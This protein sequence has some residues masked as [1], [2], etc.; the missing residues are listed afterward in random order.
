[1][2]EDEDL[3]LSGSQDDPEIDPET[4]H[5]HTVDVIFALDLLDVPGEGARLKAVQFP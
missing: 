1:L 5:S 4:A 3:D 2:I